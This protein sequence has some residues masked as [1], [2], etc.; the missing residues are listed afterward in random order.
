ME[1]KIPIELDTSSVDAAISKVTTLRDL[2]MEVRGILREIAPKE[3]TPQLNAEE[4]ASLVASMFGNMP[5]LFKDDSA[6]TERLFKLE[7]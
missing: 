6:A 5:T 7:E 1:E 4:L 2:L 3:P